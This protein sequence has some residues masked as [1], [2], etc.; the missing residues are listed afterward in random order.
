[1]VLAGKQDINTDYASF[2]RWKVCIE[3][4]PSLCVGRQLC[5]SKELQVLPAF[6]GMHNQ[7][8]CFCLNSSSLFPIPWF[9]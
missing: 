1:M 5:W 2:G 9:L 4:G 3:N 6:F 7:S 8:F